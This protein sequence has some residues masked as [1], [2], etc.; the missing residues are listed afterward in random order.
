MKFFW[1]GLLLSVL[2]LLSVSGSDYCTDTAISSK[3]CDTT[4]IFTDS[5]LNG[6]TEAECIYACLIHPYCVASGWKADECVFFKECSIQTAGAYS[7]STKTSTSCPSVNPPIVYQYSGEE[8]YY[9]VPVG[10][11]QVTMHLWGAGGGGSKWTNTNVYGGAGAYIKGVLQVTAGEVLKLVVGRGGMHGTTDP[12]SPYG[13]GG[14]NAGGGGTGGGR[15]AIIQ[16]IVLGSSAQY[17]EVVSVGAGGGAGA[18]AG[19]TGGCGGRVDGNSGVAEDVD[20]TVGTCMGNGASQSTGGTHVSGCTKSGGDGSQFLG[21]LGSQYAGG[22]GAGYYGGG[23]G[24]WAP[25]AGGGG[26]G[27]STPT[28][29]TWAYTYGAEC[30]N[31]VEEP[32]ASNAM[33]Y[34]D[35]VAAGGVGIVLRA[36][37]GLIVIEPPAYPCPRGKWSGSGDTPCTDCVEG[38]YGD[39]LSQNSIAGCK[40][41]P[42]GHYC[43]AGSDKVACYQGSYQDQEAQIRIDSCTDCAEAQYCPMGT[44][45][46]IS[47]PVYNGQG[48]S[49]VT[50]GNCMK[51]EPS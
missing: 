7:L 23:G 20:G 17:V 31:G 38:K 8:Q 4:E 33:G 25:P 42:T 50:A 35:G 16:S 13:G 28:S 41:C 12:S 30:V 26:G 36:G 44:D 10:V 43:P 19:S 37:N 49:M 21:G 15:S 22:G 51:F 9:S 45:K 48:N 18:D 24:G 14:G 39:I 40:T 46:P 3:T 27:S 5:Y 32:P 1:H 29:N 47:C 11:S 6:R 34:V 2:Q